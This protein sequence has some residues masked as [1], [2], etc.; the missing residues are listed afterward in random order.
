[1]RKIWVHCYQGDT[2]LMSY[3]FGVTETLDDAT[4]RRPSRKD[5]EANVKT[6]LT[7][8]GVAWPPYD[9]IEFKIDSL[10]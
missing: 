9:G 10:R 7:N 3:D 4:L 2:L 6:N 5:L 8:E 1:M